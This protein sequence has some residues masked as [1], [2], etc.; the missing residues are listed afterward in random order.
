MS[1]IETLLH[2]YH[3]LDLQ[4]VRLRLPLAA[5]LQLLEARACRLAPDHAI[6]FVEREIM[7]A[8]AAVRAWY[9]ERFDIIPTP[10]RVRAG[11]V[12]S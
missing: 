11:V 1:Y 2:E 3:F 10:P 9:E 5:G 6:G 8:R 4:S 12:T 7:R